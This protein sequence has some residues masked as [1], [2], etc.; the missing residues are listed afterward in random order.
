MDA[1]A[2]P[3]LRVLHQAIKPQAERYIR[4]Y[5]SALN[6]QIAP[7]VVE[8]DAIIR[9]IERGSVSG[10]ER[11]VKANWRNAAQRLSEHIDEVGERAG[12]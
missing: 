9:E 11:A 8:H 1:A 12:W 4:V 7:S 6:D 3:R 10:S 5:V 2:G